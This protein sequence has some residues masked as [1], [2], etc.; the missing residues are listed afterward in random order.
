MLRT[1]R[2]WHNLQYQICTR[3]TRTENCISSCE[4]RAAVLSWGKIWIISALN[5][6][7]NLDTLDMQTSL[8]SSCR[9]TRQINKTVDNDWRLTMEQCF[10]PN[11]TFEYSA[12]LPVPDIKS[13]QSR[14]KTGQNIFTSS[15]TTY[16][17]SSYVYLRSKNSFNMSKLL[18]EAERMFWKA[19][20]S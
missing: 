2:Y 3:E 12:M 10:Q 4:T 20:Y 13:I 8:D 9:R 15:W 6:S 5:V 18:L 19:C 16:L 17:H 14:V 7:M 11:H 1:F